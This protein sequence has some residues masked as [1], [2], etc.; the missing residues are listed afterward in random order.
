MSEIE[1]MSLEELR[2][3]FGD[4]ERVEILKKLISLFDEYQ[5]QISIQDDKIKYIPYL[6]FSHVDAYSIIYL[7]EYITISEAINFPDI[8]CSKNIKFSD[9]LYILLDL[10]EREGKNK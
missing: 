8:A 3:L 9:I 10:L 6:K 5:L 1:N 2:K 7:N 4:K